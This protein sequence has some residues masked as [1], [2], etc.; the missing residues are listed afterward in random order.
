M[1]FGVDI[2]DVT[3]KR[4]HYRMKSFTFWTILTF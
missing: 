1:E 4:R 2:I 3:I